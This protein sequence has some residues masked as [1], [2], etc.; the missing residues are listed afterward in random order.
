M[1]D[2]EI[3]QFDPLTGAASMGMGNAPSILHGMDK[4]KQIVVLEYWRNP[5]QSALNPNEGSG[6]RGDIGQYGAGQEDALRLHFVQRTQFIEQKILNRQM[7]GIGIPEERLKA[8]NILDV[9]VDP[10]ATAVAAS[11]EIINEVGDSTVV[12]M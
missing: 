4:L 3:V 7:P 11:V 10:S 1:S 6:L 5:G 2:I 12:L 9:A 8:L